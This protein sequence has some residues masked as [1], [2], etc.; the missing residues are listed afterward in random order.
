MCVDFLYR[1]KCYMRMEIDRKELAAAFSN[2]AK[3]PNYYNMHVL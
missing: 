3:V 2:F 1:K